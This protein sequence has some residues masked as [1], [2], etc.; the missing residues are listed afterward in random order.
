MKS[1]ARW[2]VG[3]FRGFRHGSA[4]DFSWRRNFKLSHYFRF[5]HI[6][7]RRW[8]NYEQLSEWYADNSTSSCS[9]THCYTATCKRRSVSDRSRRPDVSDSHSGSASALWL[10]LCVCVW[11]WQCECDTV[12][13]FTSH[14]RLGLAGNTRCGHWIELNLF[15]RITPIHNKQAMQYVMLLLG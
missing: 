10:C 12:S 14:F 8:H 7:R 3:D 4:N 13:S 6:H 15:S 5:V 9:I 11:H 2:R 1:F